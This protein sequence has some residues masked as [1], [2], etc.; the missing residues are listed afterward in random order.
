MT[1]SAL[2]PDTRLTR[3]PSYKA[4]VSP[5]LAR[6]FQIWWVRVKLQQNLSRAWAPYW[7]VGAV[8]AK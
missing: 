3:L 7:D 2:R 4:Q 6:H 5:L 8:V 1:S